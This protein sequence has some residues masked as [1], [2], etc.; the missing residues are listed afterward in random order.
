MTDVLKPEQRRKAMQHIRQKDTSIEL[1]LRKALWKK[2]YRYRKNWTA[3]RG[4][5]DIVLTK[6]HIAIFCDSEFFHGKDWPELEK[7][8]LKGSNSQ[9]W[10]GKITR[11]MERDAEVNRDLYG[12]GWTVLRFWGDDI[13]KHLEE[14][15]QTIDEAVFDQILQRKGI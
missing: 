1:S 8:I 5:P 7:R 10:Y 3:L 6:Y 15:L 13:K 4:T 12:A 11:N 2:G 14:C 9:Y